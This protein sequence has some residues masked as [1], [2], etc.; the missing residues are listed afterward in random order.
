M[1][2][3]I[4]AAK[5]PTPSHTTTLSK[6]QL[7]TISLPLPRG[8]KQFTAPSSAPAP[9]L[10]AG[11]SKQAPQN[12]S[13]LIPPSVSQIDPDFLASLTLELREEILREY[14]SAAA[15]PPSPLPKGG[16]VASPRKGKGRKERQTLLLQSPK[17]VTEWGARSGISSRGSPG[18]SQPGTSSS[19]SGTRSGRPVSYDVQLRTLFTQYHHLNHPTLKG[20]T[21]TITYT[22]IPRHP[23]TAPSSALA[24]HPPL[25]PKKP[26][27]PL[28][29]P[30]DLD[31]TVLVSL[32]PDILS[33]VL[34][35]HRTTKP[36][37]PK[38]HVTLPTP[39][40]NPLHPPPSTRCLLLP[41]PPRPL[42]SPH[43]QHLSTLPQLRELISSRM[44]EDRNTDGDGDRGFEGPNEEDVD[45]L[46]RYL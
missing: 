9:P 39:P 30:S 15:E 41:Q 38:P 43:L 23:P 14:S 28:N 22:P 29:F 44:Q 17:K 20:P 16:G 34:S 8:K 46:V 3:G 27:L 12:T 25:Q 19:P 21:A 37:L 40:P 36:P 4:L 10:V 1:R 33:E 26:K 24:P 5:N 42:K 31:H 45:I 6:P 2:A 7:T 35:N 32:P 13:D 18:R 11:P